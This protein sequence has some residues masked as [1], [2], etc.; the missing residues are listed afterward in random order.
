MEVVGL[1]SERP[2]RPFH[3]FWGPF[4]LCVG[5]VWLGGGLLCYA[6]VFISGGI[7]LVH[8]YRAWGDLGFD[9]RLP[10]GMRCRVIA[11]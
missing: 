7:L 2:F 6:F 1:F 9:H 3:L 8:K 4:H 11:I 5:Y 10:E